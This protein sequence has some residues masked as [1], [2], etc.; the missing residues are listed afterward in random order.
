[1]VVVLIL[2]ISIV[3][4][5]VVI[6]RRPKS[7]EQL[8]FTVPFVP[9]FPALSMFINISLMLRLRSAT[10]MRFLVWMA[11][12]FVVYFFYG[13]SHSGEESNLKFEPISAKSLLQT[14]SDSDDSDDD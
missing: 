8:A 10:W 1:M 3:I 7:E 2:S 14:S 6:D 11:I 4:L 13:I 12:G 9:Y 5:L